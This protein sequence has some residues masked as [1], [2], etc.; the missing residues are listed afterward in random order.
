MK[1]F[2]LI[3]LAMTCVLFPAPASSNG[4]NKEPT[5]QPSIEPSDSKNGDDEEEITVDPTEKTCDAACPT[6]TKTCDAACPIEPMPSTN[7]SGP[8]V[9]LRDFIN[10]Y[11]EVDLPLVDLPLLLAVLAVSLALMTSQAILG[12][13]KMPKLVFL[14]SMCLIVF[15]GVFVWSFDVEDNKWMILLDIFIPVVAISGMLVHCYIYLLPR[16]AIGLFVLV[17]SVTLPVVLDVADDVLYDIGIAELCGIVGGAWLV[18]KDHNQ[19]IPS[20]TN[21]RNRLSRRKSGKDEKERENRKNEG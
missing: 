5:E 9:I 4:P 17:L 13:L 2:L 19:L 14:I 16:L 6:E 18:Y 1:Q 10:H 3:L 15:A 20:W 11:G 8:S 7:F 12:F 21:F